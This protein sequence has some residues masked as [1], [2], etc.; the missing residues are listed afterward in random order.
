MKKNIDVREMTAGQINK[1]LDR[2]DKHSSELTS[3]FIREG[4]G[5]ELPSET[6]LKKDAHSLLYKE[7]LDERFILFAEIGRR[8]GPGAP[9]RLPKGFRWK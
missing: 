8:Y 6:L 1:A 9:S 3:L 7:L 5:Y 2:N 4:R